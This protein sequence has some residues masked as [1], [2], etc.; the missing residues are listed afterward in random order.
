MPAE[1]KRINL[2]AAIGEEIA[3]WGEH[4]P[5]VCIRF[6]SGNWLA[7]AAEVD[8]YDPYE[9]TL[10]EPGECEPHAMLRAGVITEDEFRRRMDEKRRARDLREREEYERL[11][12]KFEKR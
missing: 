8:P 6:K 2:E 5:M 3:A 11:R 10:D 7:L 9:A 12:R 1:E 4:G